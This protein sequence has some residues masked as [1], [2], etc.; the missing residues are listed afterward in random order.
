MLSAL[1]GVA[2]GGVSTAEA[3]KH[4]CSLRA[5]SP[6]AWTVEIEACARRVLVAAPSSTEADDVAEALAH[7]CGLAETAA[8]DSGAVAGLVDVRVLP[9][10][11]GS[12]ARPCPR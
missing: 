9:R 1:Q 7:A 6:D 2:S 8:P 4:I 10:C 3:A 12:Q 5:R 11:G